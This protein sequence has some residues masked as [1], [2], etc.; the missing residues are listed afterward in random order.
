MDGAL[1]GQQNDGNIGRRNI[2][3]LNLAGIKK[4]S[5]IGRYYS[6]GHRKQ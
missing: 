6:I 4:S 3:T 2:S 1:K 5:Y